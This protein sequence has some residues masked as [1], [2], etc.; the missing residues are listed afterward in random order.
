MGLAGKDW[1]FPV[2][3]DITDC[4][5]IGDVTFVKYDPELTA[6]TYEVK[7]RL[8]EEQPLDDGKSEFNYE[9]TLLAHLAHLFHLFHRSDGMY[10]SVQVTSSRLTKC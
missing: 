1:G 10:T 8:K 5:R 7:T 6:S 4:L 2:L 9:V 3:H